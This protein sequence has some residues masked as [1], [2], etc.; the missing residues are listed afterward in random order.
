M[1]KFLRVVILLIFILWALIFIFLFQFSFPNYIVDI[2][3]EILFFIIITLSCI[4]LGS[5]FLRILN[6]ETGILE[7]IVFSTSIGLIII[8]IFTTISGFFGL[9][10]R[11]VF[12][13]F[14]LISFLISILSLINISKEINGLQIF[15]VNFNESIFLILTIFLIFLAF[16]FSL[17]PPIFY[18]S[19]EFHIGVP[20]YYILKGKITYMDGNVFSN[21]PLFLQMIYLFA[22]L[23]QSEL[24]TTLLT[25]LMG[26]L[27]LL[28]LLSFG[29]KFLFSHLSFL[30]SIILLSLPLTTF[31]IT[32]PLQD[33]P[34]ALFFMLTFYSFVLFRKTQKFGWLILTGIFAGF[35][36]GIKYQGLFLLFLLP[37][38]ISLTG[39]NLKE[40]IKLIII[41]SLV[42]LVISSPWF[43][44][45]TLYT[46]NPIYP[47]SFKLFG[48]KK[49]NE[50]NSS[51]FLQDLHIKK[52]RQMF[53]LLYQVN[54][55]AKIFGAGGII[56]PIFII[57]IPFY[58]LGKR[59]KIADALFIVSLLNLCP[60]LATGNIR[61][62]YFSIA[63]FSLVIAY[64]IK[65]MEDF[66]LLNIAVI[67]VL[68]IIV[69]LNS[70]LS[71]SHLNL[72][73]PAL[74]L[75]L[76][77]ERKENYLRNF[78]PHYRGVEFINN[79]LPSDSVILFLYEAR[80]AYIK[81]NFISATPYD[82]NIL[83][84]ML[85]NYSNSEEIIK[86]LKKKGIT[87]VFLNE[88]EMKRIE[89]KFDYLGIR[90]PE[91]RNR[92]YILISKLKI[93][94]T[95]SG[96]YIYSLF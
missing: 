78:L 4:G 24:L 30:P 21:T 23:I 37:I 45:N 67:S 74:K 54:V 47:V 12:I 15:K 33:L 29:K 48:G 3:P 96:I 80:T 85:S 81:R 90:N 7:R 8:S 13:S 1:S 69:I 49:W 60:F 87:H 76:G 20:N 84:E 66:K 63:I 70:F 19:L 86:E 44:K 71:F 55:S 36:V 35:S 61:Y 64:G 2:L 31:L 25:F 89:G 73:N 18:D 88:M 83:K 50:E 34:L 5:L 72:V 16:L 58:L 51:R 10:N 32:T 75:I 62:S 82:T 91:I 95:Y 28:S 11:W 42:A 14:L 94:Y 9:L 43:L 27:L 46:G 68:L 41:T 65:K 93:V 38:F 92:F 40:N 39:K 79:N 57:F 22:M 17:S 52:P 59:N 53:S 56:G 77:E 26:I 6:L